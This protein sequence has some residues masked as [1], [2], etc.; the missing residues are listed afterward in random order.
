MV[1]VWDTWLCFVGVSLLWNDGNKLVFTGNSHSN[2][3]ILSRAFRAGNHYPLLA[4]E[5]GSNVLPSSPATS[6]LEHSK[7]MYRRSGSRDEGL[8]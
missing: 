4:L 2:D 5:R 8:L 6:L 7:L 3:E 1:M